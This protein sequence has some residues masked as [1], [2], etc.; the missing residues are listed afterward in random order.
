MFDVGVCDRGVY[1][2]MELVEGV[3][4]RTWLKEQARGWREVLALFVQ[5]GSG[6]AAAHEAGLVHHDFKPDNVLVGARGG[7]WSATSAWRA[8]TRSPAPT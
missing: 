8:C 3:T 1:V 4:L 6:L 7:P 2:A 5:A